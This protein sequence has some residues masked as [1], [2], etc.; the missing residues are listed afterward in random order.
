MTRK[1]PALPPDA[2]A[3]LNDF[4]VL[5]YRLFGVHASIVAPFVPVDRNPWDWGRPTL[6]DAIRRKP[7]MLERCD[8]CEA[9]LMARA[10]VRAA[11]GLCHA[12]LGQ[13]AIPI[14]LDG[15]TVGRV[16]CSPAR[17]GG[18]VAGTVRL[19]R[20]GVGE[21]AY[22][23]NLSEEV[24]ELPVVGPRRRREL[25]RFIQ[26]FFLSLFGRLRA[27]FRTDPHWYH[28]P[29]RAPH[30][31]EAWLSS[32]WTGIEPHSGEPML[33]G[34]H[35]HRAHDVLLYPAAAGRTVVLP[36]RRLEVR[37][38]E[39]VCL[40]SG[41]RYRLEAPASP[42]GDPFW[43]HF[44]SSVD[45]RALAA[46]PFAPPPP[47]RAALRDIMRGSARGFPYWYSTQ[48]KLKVLELLLALR[49]VGARPAMVRRRSPRAGTGEAIER[50]RAWLDGAAARRPRLR[51]LAAI[52]GTNVFT[53]CR[54]FRVETGLSPLA[55][56]RSVR[57]RAAGRLL[58]EGGLGPREVA[59]RL[60][61][62]TPQ[63]FHRIFRRYAG[64]TPGAWAAGAGVPSKNG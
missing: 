30:D 38:G 22:W 58:L 48:A 21:P 10:S 5:V 39:L 61:F 56:H 20:A 64:V 51:E 47:V 6:C 40:P 53:L 3:A 23:L 33:K 42:G 19:L 36:D 31:T 46:T 35:L 50:V 18:S 44:V 41:Q 27:P 14:R 7:G 13:V 62:S 55:Y 54:Q 57:V 4:H 8:A 43:I 17:L 15:R 52:A 24:R 63:H 59:R 29:V 37:Q 2:L 12:G 60:G 34:W 32:L 49:E 25:A 16:L 1:P 45:L 11:A 28:L 26:G 9:R